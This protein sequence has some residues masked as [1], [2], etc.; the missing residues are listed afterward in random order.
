MRKTILVSA[1]VLTAGM[2]LCAEENPTGVKSAEGLYVKV[3]CNAP[4]IIVKN[5]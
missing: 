3:T 4:G 2:A 1:A 5:G